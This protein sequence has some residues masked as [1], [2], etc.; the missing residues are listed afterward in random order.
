MLLNP[1]AL[2]RREKKGARV[3]AVCCSVVELV[4]LLHSLF[5]TLSYGRVRS[6]DEQ[7]APLGS[8]TCNGEV[9]LNDSAAPAEATVFS[10]DTVRTGETGT[11]TFAVSGKGTLKIS[12]HSRVAFAGNYL[13]TTEL[14]A[15]TIVL[16]TITG[17]RGLTVRIG[18]YVV[19]TYIRQESATSKITRNPDGS[20]L[21]SCLDGNA[22]VITLE[23]KAGQFLEAGQT[24]SVSARSDLVSLSPPSR[25]SGHGFH[26]GWV[27]LGLAGAGAAIAAAELGH[28]GKQS[29][30]PSTP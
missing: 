12:P 29:I 26:S 17:P 21:V 6:Q 28:G 10:G 24:L 22:G 13:Y 30:S 20:F 25:A 3:S 18:N 19:I 14:Q 7:K 15:G 4:L 8:L 16:N 1:F 27:V 11:A 9:Y 23:G 2:R 5:P